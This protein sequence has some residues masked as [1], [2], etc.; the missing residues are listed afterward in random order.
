MNN[1]ENKNLEQDNIIQDKDKLQSNPYTLMDKKQI[2]SRENFN[3]NIP[4][5]EMD[6]FK[7]EI[8][9]YKHNDPSQ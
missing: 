8:K 7:S 6:N 3:L 2:E 5:Y 9:I 4:N 1:K